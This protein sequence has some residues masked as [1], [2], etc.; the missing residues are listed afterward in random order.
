MSDYT[1]TIATGVFLNGTFNN[2]CGNCTPMTNTSGSVW[3]VTVPLVSGPIE[4]KFTIDG[5]NDQENFV[6]GE[7]CVDTN[8]DEFFNRYYVVSADTT[9]PAVCF[10]SCDVCPSSSIVE[11]S[12]N[13]EIMPNPANELFNVSSDLAISRVELIDM[14]GKN[15]KWLNSNSTKSIVV[16]VRDLN[17]GV[18]TMVVYSNNGKT[19]KRVIVE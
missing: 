19:T 9:L 5:W 8:N 6:G 17:K 10:G 3:E 1:G 7:S 2:W 11:N 15:V 14:L 4:Y 12:M 16:D 13:L 18:Y